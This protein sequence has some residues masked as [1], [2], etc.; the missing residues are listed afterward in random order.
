MPRPLTLGLI[1]GALLVLGAVSWWMLGDAPGEGPAP[2]VLVGGTPTLDA[3]STPRLPDAPPLPQRLTSAPIEAAD[4][5]ATVQ[6][7]GAVPA[8]YREALGAYTGRVLQA[9]ATGEPPAPL[10]GLRVELLGGRGSSF[11]LPLDALLGEQPPSLE[12]IVAADD[13]DEEGRFRLDGLEPRTLGVLLV[14][15]GG[16]LASVH[17]VEATPVSGAEHDLGDIVLAATATLT[18]RVLDERNAPI[19]NARVRSTDL[20]VPLPEIAAT[21]LEYR[22]GAGVVVPASSETGNLDLFFRLP[23]SIERYERHLPLPTTFTDAEGRFTLGGVRPGLVTL[24][25]DHPLHLPLAKTGVPSGA[26]GGTRD[27]GDLVL[28]EGL[29]LAVTVLDKEGVEVAGAEVLAGN[30]LALAPVALVRPAARA[31]GGGRYEARALKPGAGWV[32]A[33]A[34]ARSEFTLHEVPEI[35]AGSAT[36]KLAGGRTLTLA[37]RDEDGAPIANARLFGRALPESGAPDWILTPRTLDAQTRQPQPGRYEIG[38]LSRTTWEIAAIAPG[39][40]QQRALVELAEADAELQLVLARGQALTV[41]VLAGTAGAEP[42]E[43]AR[44]DVYPPDGT[45]GGSDFPTP[46]SAGRTGADGRLT[47]RDLPA[48]VA[49]V[50]VGHPAYALVSLEVELPAAE[51]LRVA[52]PIGGTIEGEVLIDGGPPDEPLMVFL[53]PRNGEG[54]GEMPR[55]ALTDLDG[56]FRFSGVDP[57]EVHL[58]ARERIALSAGFTSFFETMFASPLAEGE[59]LVRSGEKSWATLSSAEALD[60][61]STA[62]VSGQL[63]VNGR[64]A[65]EWRVRTFGRLRRSATTD[66]QGQFDLGRVQSGKITLQVAPRLNQGNPFGGSVHGEQLEL[67]PDERRHVTIRFDTGSIEGRVSSVGDGRPLAGANV[68]SRREGEQG[69]SWS[70]RGP[71]AVTDTEGRFALDPMGAGTWRLSV[72]EDGYAA[73]T[74]DPIEVRALTPQRGVELRLAA[75]L[76]WSGSVRFV[77]VDETP[78]WFWLIARREDGGASTNADVDRARGTYRFDTLEPGRWVITAATDLS[79]EFETITIDVS[80]PREGHELSFVP[81]VEDETPVPGAK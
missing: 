60:G 58:E 30:L 24:G 68:S 35:A 67:Q 59:V 26:A 63:L 76:S 51:E 22:P 14:D 69:F 5:A 70:S 11:A 18:G 62:F 46:V 10:P 28:G 61:I 6:L 3:P 79:V 54:D 29:A 73:F 12:L 31:L 4:V 16:A 45:L 78:G 50:M 44:V 34:D 55:F 74:S 75:G 23:P 65:P 21:F 81:K 32:A 52:L 27:L 15:P 64:P 25:I 71:S 66:A 2:T 49:Q 53:N 33:R 57:G 36:V 77:G 9:S 48:G 13:T 80:A 47:L 7:D 39:F 17:M 56:R 8:S 40:V 43:H 1:A 19:A 42:V 41:L 20:P 37:L 38:E 72:R